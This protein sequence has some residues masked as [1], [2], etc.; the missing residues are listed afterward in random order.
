[1]TAFNNL[2][3]ASDTDI[4]HPAPSL[5]KVS[6]AAV[7][8]IVLLVVFSFILMV[9]AS[10]V[11][12]LNEFISHD[13][14]MPNTQPGQTAL[15]LISMPT[16]YFAILTLWAWRGR[17]NVLRLSASSTASLIALAISSGF[18][19]FLLTVLTTYAL[20]AAGAALKPS[21]QAL[22]ETLSQQ[23]PI[24]ITFLAV[25]VAPIFEELFFRKQLFARFASAGYLITGYVVSS[26][27]FALMHEPFPTQGLVRWLLMLGL[28]SFMGVVFAAV[29][30]KTGR[31]WP[32]MLAH[33]SNNIF[34]MSVLFISS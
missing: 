3:F 31:L 5:Y 32:A 11:W 10:A 1:M 25:I 30:R 27:L 18:V 7:L 8:D 15:L 13:G 6:G 20:N 26:I 4:K 22:I 28:Y 33:A 34:A 16:L 29:Y 19:L 24:A 21:N 23:W 14:H 2:D 12:A 17:R 9:A